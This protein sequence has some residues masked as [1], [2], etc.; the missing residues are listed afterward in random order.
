MR[1]NL[2]I[3][4]PWDGSH[5]QTRPLKITSVIP[6]FHYFPIFFSPK[7]AIS[8]PRFLPWFLFLR[9]RSRISPVR[10]VLHLSAFPSNPGFEWSGDFWGGWSPIPGISEVF[11]P[12]IRVQKQSHLGSPRPPVFCSCRADERHPGFKK[13][14]KTH[15]L[16]QICDFKLTQLWHRGC[17]GPCRDRTSLPDGG[18]VKT[19]I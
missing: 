16:S 6:P 13:N 3:W 1:W 15:F 14:P 9:P 10:E 17:S 12:R 2:P 5:L 4:N 18:A 7:N 19:V 8:V 11:C